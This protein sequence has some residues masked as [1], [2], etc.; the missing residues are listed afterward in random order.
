LVDGP[1]PQPVIVDSRGRTPLTARLWQHAK[2]PWIASALGQDQTGPIDALAAAGAS[3]LPT[4]L[5]NG[6][7]DLAHLLDQ[8]GARGVR[9]LMVEG[10][11]TI[12]STLLSRRLVDYAVI[13]VSPRFLGGTTVTNGASGLARAMPTLTNTSYT[14]S[15]NNLRVW[16]DGNYNCQPAEGHMT[17]AQV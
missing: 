16:G 13:T 8:L 10:G 4:P 6:Q 15:G 1:S 5:H 12:I 3:I 7:L 2:P 9:S 14:P 11:A 17:A